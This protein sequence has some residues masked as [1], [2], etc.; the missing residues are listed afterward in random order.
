MEI[1]KPIQKTILE[2]EENNFIKNQI[3]ICFLEDMDR[4]FEEL[5]EI[6]LN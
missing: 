6:C 2:Q 3:K 4:L 1:N 5:D